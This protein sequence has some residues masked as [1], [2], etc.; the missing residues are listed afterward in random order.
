M[1][2]ANLVAKYTPISSLA[3][4]TPPPGSD[5][6]QSTLPASQ[7]D[8]DIYCWGEYNGDKFDE[9]FLNQGFQND[10]QG[11]TGFGIIAA[12]HGNCVDKVY[13]GMATD[14]QRKASPYTPGHWLL[15]GQMDPSQMDDGVYYY[16]TWEIPGLPFELPVGETIYL[17]WATDQEYVET[18]L[19]VYQWG[20]ISS[21]PYGYPF[22]IYDGTN[23]NVQLYDAL[24]YTFTTLGAVP[25]EDH[26]TVTE[27]VAANCYWY[28]NSCH[29]NPEGGCSAYTSQTTCEAANCYWYNNSCHDSLPADLCQL[30]S[31]QSDCLAANCYWYKRYLWES[32][33]CWST[34][35]SELM[36]WLPVI[37]TGAGIGSLAVAYLLTRK[38]AEPKAKAKVPLYYLP[39]PK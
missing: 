19:K 31:N 36:Y 12:R 29:T 2:F 22:D 10:R 28:N 32:D 17:I 18:P 35:K 33:A 3:A 38:K 1:A 15:Y 23:W 24:F 9:Q 26:L 13:I 7:M 5:F 37:V 34:Q 25:C 11:L 21:G 14:S 27:C 39:I 16:V 8:M 4:P 20:G 6:D 30:H